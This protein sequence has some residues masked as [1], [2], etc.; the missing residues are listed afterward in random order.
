VV[1]HG[2]EPRL[3]FGNVPEY[4][5][6]QVLE[7]HDWHTAQVFAEIVRKME[8]GHTDLIDCGGIGDC[9]LALPTGFE[10]QFDISREFLNRGA[11]CQLVCAAIIL[12]DRGNR[13]VLVDEEEV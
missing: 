6:P 9:L 5:A 8:E 10:M 12:V 11:V 2:E 3:V 13:A 7:G 1:V 4:G